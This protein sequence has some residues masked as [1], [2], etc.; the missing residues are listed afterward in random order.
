M[1]DLTDGKDLL[2]AAGMPYVA[3][4]NQYVHVQPNLLNSKRVCKVFNM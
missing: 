4:G 1:T 3:A 2:C